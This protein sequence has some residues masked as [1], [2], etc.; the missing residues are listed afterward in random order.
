V[1]SISVSIGYEPI[2]AESSLPADLEELVK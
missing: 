2:W 1:R